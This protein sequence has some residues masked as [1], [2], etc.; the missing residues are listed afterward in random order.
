MLWCQK[1]SKLVNFVDICKFSVPFHLQS[2]KMP[3]CPKLSD[4]V[5]FVEIDTFCVPLG[6]TFF[7]CWITLHQLKFLRSAIAKKKEG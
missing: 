1:W 6:E 3:W 7:I 5:N 2:T 4:L